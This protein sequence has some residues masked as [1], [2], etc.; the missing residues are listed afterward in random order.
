MLRTNR[1]GFSLSC[2]ARLTRCVHASCSSGHSGASSG[3]EIT[4]SS[5]TSDIVDCGGGGGVSLGLQLCSWLAGC[6][7]VMEK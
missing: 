7:R 2:N 6:L 4:S 3:E 1:D 5:V